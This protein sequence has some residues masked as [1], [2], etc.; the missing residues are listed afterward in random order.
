MVLGLPFFKRPDP[1]AQR[2]SDDATTRAVVTAFVAVLRAKLEAR[3][4]V[5]IAQGTSTDSRADA[6]ALAIRVDEDT[7]IL[8]FLGDEL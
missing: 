5:L 2:P 6:E 8:G 7:V 4:S 3:R 1:P